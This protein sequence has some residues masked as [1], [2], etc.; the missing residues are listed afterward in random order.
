MLAGVNPKIDAASIAS[1]VATSAALAGPPRPNRFPNA[2][3]RMQNPAAMS[4]AL[5]A[6]CPFRLSA[7]VFPRFRKISVSAENLPPPD[8]V[9]KA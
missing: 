2:I 4:V 5:I 9:R 6:K 7:S 1:A 8:I 3:H